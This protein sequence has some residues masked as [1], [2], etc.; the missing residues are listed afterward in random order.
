MHRKIRKPGPSKER[1]KAGI[2]LTVSARPFFPAQPRVAMSAHLH[3]RLSEEQIVMRAEVKREVR[4]QFRRTI[5]WAT[6][7]LSLVIVG[8]VDWKTGTVLLLFGALVFLV[9]EKNL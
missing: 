4:E 8:S 5:I 6:Y 7:G 3:G 1:D 2:L 9:R